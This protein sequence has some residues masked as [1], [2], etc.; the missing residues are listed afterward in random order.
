MSKKIAHTVEL[1]FRPYPEKH[2]QKGEVLLRPEQPV[3]EVFY[4]K[5]GAVTQCD[6]SPNGSEVIVN[7]FK[8][9][10]FFPMSHALN[11]NPNLYYFFEATTETAIQ[12]APISDVVYF[13]ENHPDILLDLLKRVYGGTDGL[14]RRMAHLMGGSARSRLLFELLNAGYRFGSVASDGQ[15]ILKINESDLAKR[16]G[17]SRET[18]S[19]TMRS[20]KSTGIVAVSQKNITIKDLS[21]LEELLGSDL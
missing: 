4:L 12:C 19:R 5:E 6:I 1:F 7:V 16:S 14:L 3:T 17:L 10:A 11:K 15:V 13:L 8:P 9:G 2:F 18:V 20:I 21:K